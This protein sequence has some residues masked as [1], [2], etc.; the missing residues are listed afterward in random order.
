[1]LLCVLMLCVMVCLMCLGDVMCVDVLMCVVDVVVD[2][3]GDV[4]E[5]NYCVFWDDVECIVMVL[6]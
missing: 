3:F 6:E 4:G 2:V 1:M 5:A